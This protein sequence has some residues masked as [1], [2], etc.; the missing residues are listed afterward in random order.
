MA[1]DRDDEAQPPLA[2]ASGADVS[3][4]TSVSGLGGETLKTDDSAAGLAPV[5]QGG[6]RAGWGTDAAETGMVPPATN[7]GTGQSDRSTG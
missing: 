3:A 7:D 2:G 6:A 4:G 5:D 1:D